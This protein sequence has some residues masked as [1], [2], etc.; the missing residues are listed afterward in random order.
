MRCTAL[1]SLILVLCLAMGSCYCLA[2]KP[3]MLIKYPSFTN[4]PKA[5]DAYRLQLIALIL[6]QTR[7]EYGDYQMERPQFDADSSKRQALLLDEGSRVNVMLSSPGTSIS[8]VDVIAIPF[9]ILRSLLGNRVCLINR[10]QKVDF[11]QVKDSASLSSISLGQGFGWTDLDIYAFNNI[12]PKTAPTFDGLITML[13][14]SRFGCLPL[15]VDEINPI[16]QDYAVQWPSLGIE[17][18]LLIQYDFPVYFYISAKEPL[19][20]ERFKLGIKKIQ[21]NGEFDRLFAQFYQKKLDNL[22]VNKRRV[23]CLKSPYLPLE[24]QCVARAAPE[25]R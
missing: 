7:G 9:D 16:L 10:N 6:E 14:A 12:Q 1:N 13:A 8:Q 11:S 24:N 5:P 2:A 25:L 3:P 20:A 17:P 19:L 4:A 21:A 18:S 23:I 22:H 15:G